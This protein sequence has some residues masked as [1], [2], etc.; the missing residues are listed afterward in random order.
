M[1]KKLNLYV[2]RHGETYLNRYKRMQGWADSPLTDEGKVLA[3]EAGKRLENVLF[4]RVYTSDSGRTVETA[5]IV[6]QQNKISDQLDI[7][8]MKEFR[9]IFF[10]SFEGE[11][12]EVFWDTLARENGFNNIKDILQNNN[13]EELS[14]LIKKTD[15]LQHAENHAEI[16]NRIEKGLQEI[17][18]ES[19]TRT[20]ENI[21]LVSHGVTIR[22]ILFRYSKELDLTIDIK[23]CSFSIL[24]YSQERFKV[25]SFNQ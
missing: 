20:K 19:N 6:L 14:D 1:D 18:A 5:E 7:R 8:K 9:E 24:E 23:N 21:L 2:M 25:I 16:W 10:G 13:M 3:V 22:H 11:K 17:V 12:S 15:P 4:D